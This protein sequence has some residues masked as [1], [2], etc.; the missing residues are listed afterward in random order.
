MTQFELFAL[1]TRLVVLFAFITS[2]SRAL[3]QAGKGRCDAA[4][5]GLSLAGWCAP[6]ADAA[7]DAARHRPVLLP[8]EKEGAATPSVCLEVKAA[9]TPFSSVPQFH[10]SHLVKIPR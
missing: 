3:R 2:Y 4:D 1:F 9:A 6:G 10:P 8:G 7:V 5:S